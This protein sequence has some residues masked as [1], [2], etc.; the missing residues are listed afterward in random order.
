[1]KI[2]ATVALRTPDLPPAAKEAVTAIREQCDRLGQLVLS[3]LD[4]SK[5]DEGR[6]V[7]RRTDTDVTA[8]VADVVARSSAEATQRRVTVTGA[9]GTPVRAS[10]DGDLMR[11]VLENLVD[12]AL[13]HTPAGGTVRVSASRID[14][15][16]EI[17]VHDSGQ[18]V[19]E[20]MRERIFDPF[21]QIEGGAGATRGGRGLGLAFCRA[22]VE[23]HG[24]TIA[25]DGS[26]AGA[27]FVIRLPEEPT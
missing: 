16:L 14:G 24:G 22:A 2:H 6:L 21:V 8:L 19:P 10:L 12:N 15:T 9:E 26:V 23:A 7:A 3:L 4:L 20:A 11:R 27:C 17:R 13:R 1:M 18:G 25:V 5:A